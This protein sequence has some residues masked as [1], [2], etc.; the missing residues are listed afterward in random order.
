MPQAANGLGVH[1]P[2]GLDAQRHRE[3]ALSLAELGELHPDETCSAGT[4]KWGAGAQDS[5]ATRGGGG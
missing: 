2:L 1:R 4:L 5:I 3:A